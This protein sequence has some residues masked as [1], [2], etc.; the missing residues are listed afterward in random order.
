MPNRSPSARRLV[1]LVLGLMA[2]VAAPERG[3]GALAGEPAPTSASASAPTPASA[4]A[5]A[6]APAAAGTGDFLKVRLALVDLR[7]ALPPDLIRPEGRSRWDLRGV[8]LGD[9]WVRTTGPVDGAYS[10]ADGAGAAPVATRLYRDAGTDGNGSAA[11][12]AMPHRA[13]EDLRPGARDLLMVDE[14]ADEAA[15]SLVI[16]SAIAGI[17]WVELPSGPREVVLQRLLIQKRAAGAAGY[18]PERLVHRWIDPRAGVVAEVSGPPAPDGRTR[19]AVSAAN[20][21]ETVLQGA[22]DL[23]LYL[24]DL[25]EPVLSDIGFARDRGNG[26]TIASLTPAPGVTTA[27]DLIAL[28]Y[29][30]F[31]GNTTGTE[32][33]Y[34]ATPVSQAATCNYAQC[35]Y[36]TPGAHLERS[37]LNWNVPGGLV[38]TNAVT[39]LEVRASD[40]VVWLRAGAQKEGVAGA[41]GAGESRFC[42]STFDG[43]IRTPAP[44]WSLADHGVPGGPHYLAAGDIWSSTPFNCEQN[45]YNQLCGAA[46]LFDRLWSKACGTHTGTQFGSAIKGGVV[47]LPSGHTFNAMLVRTV[48]D[49]CVYLGSTCSVFGKVDEV[50]TVNYLWQVPRVGTVARFQ[51]LQNVP[52]L[53]SFTTLAEAHIAFGLYPPLSIAVTAIGD[54]SV[55]LSWDPGLDTHRIT[56]YKV[57]WDTDSGAATPYAF[58]SEIAPGQATIAGTA[59][60]ITGL[61][62]GTAYYFTVTALSLFADPS[63]GVPT[64][65]ESDRYPTQLSG[66]PGFVYPI[67]V[68][69]TTTGG[70]C[71]PTAEVAG[72]MV[73]HDGSGVQIC[74]DPVNDP[75]LVGYQVL[76]ADTA[77]SDAGFS[78][79]ADTGLVTCWNGS[80]ASR[81][82]LVTARGTGGNGPWGH[83][84]R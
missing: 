20:V 22:A 62:P 7:A 40:S 16:D 6:L 65:F 47:T 76:G 27:G 28:S 14:T 33:A 17:G 61:V 36:T 25:W 32:V 54:D 26:T 59:A 75:C 78:V 4:P 18:V 43:V 82:F 19:L 10:V 60:Q 81:Y 73:T 42:Y 29:W 30:D 66:D 52:D 56:G 35:G 21:L 68:L 41:F 37:D 9:R 79:L 74:W 38:K 12:F 67:E 53:T 24:D 84:G 46:Q 8:I 64:R 70:T 51:S 72:V 80:P 83:Y 55:S 2:A 23:R 63:T 31:S 1:P 15:A 49:F 44:L 77:Q 50:R 34:T 13:G 11:R 39:E 5:S 45:L 71:I 69:A 48:A 57:Y 58:D 3:A